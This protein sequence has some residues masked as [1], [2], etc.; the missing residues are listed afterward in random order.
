MGHID[1]A[2]GALDADPEIGVPASSPNEGSVRVRPEGCG[3]SAGSVVGDGT[4]CHARV[5]RAVVG[6]GLRVGE[7][8]V[9]EDELLGAREGRRDEEQDR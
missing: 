9:E 3:L 4:V 5:R 8:D 6:V 1:T 7:S 2:P